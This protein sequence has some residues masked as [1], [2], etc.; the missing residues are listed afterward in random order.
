MLERAEE[1]NL[2]THLLADA[3]K[4]RGWARVP[5]KGPT[6]NAEVR[7]SYFQPRMDSGLIRLGLWFSALLLISSE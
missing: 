1:R 3:E 5:P 6:H 4:R 2:R 7:T